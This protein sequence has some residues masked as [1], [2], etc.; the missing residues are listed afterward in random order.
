M[1]TT[2]DPTST[3]APAADDADQLRTQIEQTREELGETVASLSEKA[4]V[5]AQA[6]AKADEVKD[7]VHEVE[8][9]AKVKVEAATVQAK[10]NPVPVALGALAL[11]LVLNRFRRRRKARRIERRLME[12]ALRHTLSTGMSVP[13]VLVDRQQAAA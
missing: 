6:A 9:K 5:K 1:S 12:D 3:T 4:D 7:K 10:Q 11:L 13:A 2:H 8:E